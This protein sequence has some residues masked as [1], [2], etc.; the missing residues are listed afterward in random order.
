MSFNNKVFPVRRQSYRASYLSPPQ[1]LT[2]EN[3][4]RTKNKLQSLDCIVLYWTVLLGAVQW[5]LLCRSHKNVHHC[6]Y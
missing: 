2:S 4:P 5:P 3:R 6:Y 1:M